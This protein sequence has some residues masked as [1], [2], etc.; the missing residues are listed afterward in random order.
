MADNINSLVS[1]DLHPDNIEHLDGYSDDTEV[2]LRAARNAFQSAYAFIGNIYSVRDAAMSDPTLTPAAAILKTDEF[3][4]SR[5]ASVTKLF[6]GAV[7]ALGKTINASEQELAAPVLEKGAKLVSQEVRSHLKGLNSEERHKTIQQALN[8]GNEVVMCALLGAPALLSG[9]TDE[10]QVAYLRMWREKVEPVKAQ[11]LRAMR[12]AKE[13]LE[14]RGGLVILQ[15]DKAVGHLTDPATQRRI[16]PET[17][18]KQKAAAD[19]VYA[20]HA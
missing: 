13:R 6:D 10:M 8:G 7:T 2:F 16:T 4:R 5:L 1:A 11:R 3:A 15:M 17:L 9:L 20:A 12:A 14:Q 18:R 19:S